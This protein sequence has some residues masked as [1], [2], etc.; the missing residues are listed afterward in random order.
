LSDRPSATDDEIRQRLEARQH[1][2]AFE[3]LLDRFQDTVFRLAFSLLRDETQADDTAQDVFVRVWKGLPG[4][5]GGASLSTWICTITRNPCFT[6]LKRQGGRRMVSLDDSMA[7]EGSYTLAALQGSERESGADA[8]VQTLLA[9]LPE[10]YR[11]VIT[12]LLLVLGAGA[13]LW[14]SA[15]RTWLA[16]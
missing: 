12:L 4:Y 9:N 14:K 16:V 13:S 15:R 7:G 10:K 11:R 5:R 2:E 3:L 1:R 8:D 6:E